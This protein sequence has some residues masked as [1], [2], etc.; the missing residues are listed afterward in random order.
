MTDRMKKI[1]KYV[2]IGVCGALLTAVLVM[3][4]LAGKEARKG[5]VCKGVEIV[6]L[7]SMENSFVSE[8]DIKKYLD[9][10]FGGYIGR[11]LD[12]LDLIKAEKII[13]GRSA[14][15][16]SHAFVTRD[17]LLRINVTQR[18]PVVR[19]QKPDGG[20]YADAEGYIF[21]LQSSYASHVQIVDG[22]IPLAANSGYK[23]ALTDPD[24]KEWLAKMMK[25][26]N[27]I[28]NSRTWKDKIVQISVEKS[29]ELILVPREGKQLFYFGQPVEV[30]DKFR[31]MEMYY[32]H[33]VPEKGAD[34]YS[35][36]DVRYD[37]QIV[38]R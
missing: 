13:D 19:F 12:S 33:I 30:E 1:E 21:P 6:I 7:D 22:A 37:G 32:T 11:S 20:F 5:L 3:S 25:V 34:A 15:K 35:R 29:G 31:K 16:K 18:R 14:V 17:S 28:E 24:E 38:C 8:A 27:Y 23:G 2:L 4:C 26:V 9:K 36:V 10:E